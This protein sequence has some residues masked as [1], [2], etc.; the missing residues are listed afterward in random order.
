MEAKVAPA[1][2]H[3]AIRLLAGAALAVPASLL[4]DFSWE[5]TV[6]VDLT[7]A[8]PHLALYLALLTA[9]SVAAF[10]TRCGAGAAANSGVGL[11]LWGVAAYA[12]AFLFDRWWQSL[13]GLSAGVWHPPQILKAASFVAVTYGAW[14]C[15]AGRVGA[16]A[17]AGGAL[18][19]LAAVLILPSLL[20][21]RQRGAEFLQWSAV[22]FP[23]VL[24]LLAVGGSERFGAV[25][26]AAVAF[27]L[28]LLAVW[29]LPLV[30]GSPQVAPVHQ[31]RDH[32]LPPPF[33][34][35]LFGPALA[36]DFFLRGWG[37][38]PRAGSPWLRAAEAGLAFGAVFLA[39]QWHFS[40]FLLS[41]AADGWIFAGG[42]RHWPF[43]LQI[44]DG[45]RSAFWRLP[46]DEITPVVVVRCLLLATL[47][48]RLG[49]ALAPA[50]AKE[51][52]A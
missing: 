10:I 4:W 22:L 28:G 47:S 20:A 42:G 35:L 15:A 37:A 9:A 30:P 44:E 50:P 48:T 27:G 51:V 3:W 21:N 2:P 31:P 25:R 8:P 45:M 19:A 14:R 11:V 23:G 33:P 36:V 41:P 29:L 26:A 7:F 39:L 38:K 16:A 24:A 17:A 13:Y 52:Q 5:S 1:A 34:L 49:L 6:G 18:L 40:A 43:F 32:L 12:V 46:G